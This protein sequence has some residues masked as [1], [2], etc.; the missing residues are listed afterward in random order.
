MIRRELSIKTT[1]EVVEVFTGS[2]NL[3]EKDPPKSVRLLAGET[4]HDK[5]IVRFGFLSENGL[6]DKASYRVASPQLKM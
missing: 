6:T 4:F 3:L 1:S 5:E 2:R